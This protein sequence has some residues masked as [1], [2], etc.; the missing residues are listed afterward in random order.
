MNKII[1]RNREALGLPNKV[2]DI[3]GW[4]TMNAV[5]V[6]FFA[7]DLGGGWLIN[8]GVVIGR[9]DNLRGCNNV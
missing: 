9:D 6:R 3:N 5:P 1:K 8:D 7:N 4:K 2:G